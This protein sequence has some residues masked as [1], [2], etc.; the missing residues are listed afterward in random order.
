MNKRDVV[1]LVGIGVVVYVATFLAF[2]SYRAVTTTAAKE[3]AQPPLTANRSFAEGLDHRVTPLLV[4]PAERTNAPPDLLLDRTDAK[5]NSPV[6][7]NANT[8]PEPEEAD[9]EGGPEPERS[10]TTGLPDPSVHE[11]FVRSSHIVSTGYNQTNET[12]YIKFKGERVYSYLSVPEVTFL[13]F[14]AARSKGTYA[15]R[16]IYRSFESTQLRPG[17]VSA[18]R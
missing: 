14:L 11:V 4:A 9:L 18:S 13:E 1:T 10:S 8:P 6:A 17:S 7:A 5:L 3:S 12:L 2:L 15:N 16:N